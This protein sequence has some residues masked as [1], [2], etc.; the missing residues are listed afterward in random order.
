MQAEQLLP[1]L[2]TA[3]ALAMVGS[4]LFFTP[5]MPRF[6]AWLSRWFVVHGFLSAV[7][8]IAGM[9]SVAASII[10]FTVVLAGLLR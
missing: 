10:L 3:I 4:G 5:L 8:M 1:D 7:M 6:N 9:V 2:L